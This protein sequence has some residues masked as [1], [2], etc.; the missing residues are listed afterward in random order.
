MRP[1][2]TAIQIGAALLLVVVLSSCPFKVGSIDVT[3]DSQLEPPIEVTLSGARAELAAGDTMTVTAASPHPVDSYEWF[4]Q[5]ESIGGGPDRS[6]QTVG[7][8]LDPG[9]YRLDVVVVAGSSSGSAY[10]DFSVVDS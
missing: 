9:T 1:I 7:A 10:A 6:S 2:R 5:G 3:V 8:G 4:L